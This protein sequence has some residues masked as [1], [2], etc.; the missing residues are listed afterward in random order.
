MALAVGQQLRRREPAGDCWD[1]VVITGYFDLG[2]T[3]EL[4]ISPALGFAAPIMATAESLLSVYTIDID[5]PK[6]PK[7]WQTSVEEVTA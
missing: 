1:S 7:T 6:P 2:E 5:P 3:S 4:V